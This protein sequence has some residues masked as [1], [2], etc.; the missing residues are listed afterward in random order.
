MKVKKILV[1]Q[2]K[3]LSENSPYFDIIEKFGVKI[4]FRPFIKVDPIPTKEFKEQKV[5]ILNHSAIVFTSRNG[6]D[7]FF[8]ICGDLR[9]T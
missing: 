4:D 5:S 8:R 3:P 7:H 9:V 1:S 6:I 2:P